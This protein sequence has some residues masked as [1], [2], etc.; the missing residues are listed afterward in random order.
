MLNFNTHNQTPPNWLLMFRLH[1][2]LASFGYK[3]IMSIYSKGSPN[4]RNYI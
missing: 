2:I 4:A 1:V 3:K